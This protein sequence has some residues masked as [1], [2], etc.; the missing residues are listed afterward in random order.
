[1]RMPS[2]RDIA[3]S[4]VMPCLNEERTI[5]PCIAGARRAL[6]RTGLSS[7][8]IVADNGSTDRSIDIAETLGAKV[9]HEPR[10]GY[11]NVYLKGMAAA[12]GRIMII[13]DS[14]GTYDFG[15]I[16]RF[17]APFRKGC[18]VVIGNRFLGT[19]KPG[20]MPWLHRYIGNPLLSK[21]LNLFFSTE[22]GDAHCGMRS[23][24]RRAFRRMRLQSSGMEFASEMIIRASKTGLRMVEVPVTYSPRPDGS[25]SKL[26]SFPDGWRHLKFMLLYSPTWLFFIPGLTLSGFGLLLLLALVRGPVRI[27]GLFFDLHYMVLGSLLAILGVQILGLG[28]SA[29]VVAVSQGLEPLSRMFKGFVRNFELERGILAGGAVFTAGFAVNLYIF[30]LWLSVG[31]RGQLYIRETILAMTLMVVGVQIGFSS[32][33]LHF[34]GIEK[35][36]SDPQ[37]GS[38]F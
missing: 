8:I 19:I 32:F 33:F 18:D 9:V 26:R 5:G 23:L 21:I 1:M 30:I 7:E 16:E 35:C 13:A 25:F 24:T 3:V 37:N 36:K 10:K 22:I 38:T 14:D 29:K 34:L 11:G 2:R 31:F 4:V 12:K 27:F 28:L 15:E 6:A 17:L 20:A